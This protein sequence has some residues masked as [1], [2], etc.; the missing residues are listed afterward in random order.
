MTRAALGSHLLEEFEAARAEL[1]TP[2]GVSRFKARAPSIGR[3]TIVLVSHT[4]SLLWSERRDVPIHEVGSGCLR[5]QQH[6]GYF[7]GG[8]SIARAPWAGK[9]RA[10][11]VATGRSRPNDR[12]FGCRPVTMP[13]LVI[14]SRAKYP[15]PRSSYL[16]PVVLPCRPDPWRGRCL[17]RQRLQDGGGDNLMRH[18]ITSWLSSAGAPLPVRVA[19]STS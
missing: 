6:Y 16:A 5:V 12:V 3:R 2:T 4:R 10:G 1:Q 15:I 9:L 8:L 7:L 11:A 19:L 13:R 17:G 14:S 18:R